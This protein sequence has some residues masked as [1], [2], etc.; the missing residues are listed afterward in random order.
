MKKCKLLRKNASYTKNAS[1][2]EKM[3]VIVKKFNLL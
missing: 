2:N 1:Y 3:Q